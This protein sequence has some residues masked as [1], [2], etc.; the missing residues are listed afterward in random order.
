[1]E[2]RKSMIQ[3]YCYLNMPELLP[4]P[5]HLKPNLDELARLLPQWLVSAVM[6]VTWSMTFRQKEVK[7]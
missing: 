2:V 7:Q 5:P 4:Q 6:P 1:M 3:I